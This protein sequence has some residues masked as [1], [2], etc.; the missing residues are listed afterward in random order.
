MIINSR[1]RCYKRKQ[2]FKL[3]F[4]KVLYHL[5]ISPLNNRR[6]RITA[7]KAVFFLYTFKGQILKMNCYSKPNKEDKNEK[8]F[9][10]K[11]CGLNCLTGAQFRR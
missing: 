3:S 10:P 8:I 6:Y 9:K 1:T 7:G 4:L 11:R 2:E 5:K